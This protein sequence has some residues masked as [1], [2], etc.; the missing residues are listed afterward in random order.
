VAETIANALGA[1]R[2]R[3]RYTV[4]PFA[5][6]GHFLRGKIPARLMRRGMSRYL[7]IGR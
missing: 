1:K 4:G 3:F 7:G 6:L 5:R 2:P